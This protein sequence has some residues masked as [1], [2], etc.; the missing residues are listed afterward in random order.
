MDRTDTA[1]STAHIAEQARRHAAATLTNLRTGNHQVLTGIGNA[2]LDKLAEVGA[3]QRFVRTA[4]ACGPMTAGNML[5]ELIEECVQ[6][7][8]RAAAKRELERFAR[9]ATVAQALSAVDRVL[10]R[11]KPTQQ[12]HAS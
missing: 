3:I 5:R 12:Q 8:A 10:A 4:M 2:A 7:D 9:P 1:V 6:E 11:M